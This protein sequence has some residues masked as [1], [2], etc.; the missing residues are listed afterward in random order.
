[1]FRPQPQE[2]RA[3]QHEA[4]AAVRC[5][6]AVQE[7]FQ[8]IARQQG[9]MLVAGLPGAIEQPRGNR[10]SEIGLPGHAIASR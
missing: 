9:L 3:L 5:A 6:E 2:H 7:P 10:G 4:V 1:L 8:A